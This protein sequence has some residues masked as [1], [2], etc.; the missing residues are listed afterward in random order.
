MLNRLHNQSVDVASLK[1]ENFGQCI[2]ENAEELHRLFAELVPK[3]E[4]EANDY[5]RKDNLI[6]LSNM[7]SMLE[8]CINNEE[9]RKRLLSMQTGRPQ[10]MFVDEFQDTD[11]QYINILKTNLIN[12]YTDLQNNRGSGIY[13]AI[14][15]YRDSKLELPAIIYNY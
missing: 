6:H 13:S 10:Y 15:K 4:K 14:N 12:E 1:R 3:I 8:L 7:M 5:F 9:N 2:F 11:A